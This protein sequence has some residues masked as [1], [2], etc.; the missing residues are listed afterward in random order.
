MKILCLLLVVA[1]VFTQEPALEAPLGSPVSKYGK[2][3]VQGI[4]LVS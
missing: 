3:K 4:Q 2:L 1:F